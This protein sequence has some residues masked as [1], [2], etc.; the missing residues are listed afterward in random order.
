M[1]KIYTW[2]IIDSA[3]IPNKDGMEN[4]VYKV[5]Y[6]KRVVEEI[7]GKKYEA[8]FVGETK[9]PA[10]NPDNFTPISELSTE[11]V[12]AWLESLLNQEFI[13]MR[14]DAILTYKKKT[15]NFIYIN[16]PF[17]TRNAPTPLS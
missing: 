3:I 1:S 5:H 11:I 13:N 16:P 12:S 15:E 17:S 10:P 7:D 9:I 4:I 6:I 14:L 2:R 8:D